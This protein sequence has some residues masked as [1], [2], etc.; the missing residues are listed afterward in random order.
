MQHLCA[1]ERDGLA[2]QATTGADHCDLVPV[3]IDGDHLPVAL[4]SPPLECQ[5]RTMSHNERPLQCLARL[6]APHCISQMLQQGGATGL[7]GS[8]EEVLLHAEMRWTLGLMHV[9]VDE[10]LVAEALQGTGAG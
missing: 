9:N 6:G 5:L 3:L 10:H 1:L 7:S 4:L 2:H 8:R